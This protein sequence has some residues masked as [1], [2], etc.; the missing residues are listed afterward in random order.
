[1]EGG[2]KQDFIKEVDKKENNNNKNLVCSLSTRDIAPDD[3]REIMH[4]YNFLDL[5]MQNNAN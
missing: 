1:M 4:H 3:A 2:N 5:A